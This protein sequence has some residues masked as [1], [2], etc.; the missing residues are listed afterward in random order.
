MLDECLWFRLYGWCYGVVWFCCDGL[1]GRC[2]F[3]CVEYLLYLWESSGKSLFWIGLVEV[4]K[5]CLGGFWWMDVDCGGGLCG[6]GWG[7]RD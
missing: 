4:F 2:G 5:D 3:N 1:I 6:L 7:R